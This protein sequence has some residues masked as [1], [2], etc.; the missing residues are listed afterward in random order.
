M[1]LRDPTA[2]QATR[3]ADRKRY[4]HQRD[5]TPPPP[6]TTWRQFYEPDEQPATEVEHLDV[7][8]MGAESWRRSKAYVRWSHSRGDFG[9]E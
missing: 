8:E 9:I 3:T 4:A 6:R 1:P 5:V 7:R 2:H